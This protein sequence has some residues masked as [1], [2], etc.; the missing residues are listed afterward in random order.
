MHVVTPSRA[1]GHPFT[2]AAPLSPGTPRALPV[3]AGV[4]ALSTPNTLSTA[5]LLTCA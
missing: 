4:L 2:Y 1:R 5:T 3:N